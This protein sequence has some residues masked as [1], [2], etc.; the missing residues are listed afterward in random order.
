MPFREDF[1]ACF[2]DDN[3]AEDGLPAETIEC[4]IPPQKPVVSASFNEDFD[5]CFADDEEE[6]EE[7]EETGSTAD[8]GAS[9]IA[10]DVEKTAAETAEKR[11]SDDEFDCVR[12][13]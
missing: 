6:D 12:D 1:D 9:N 10:A 11:R 3:V 7:Q 2:A 8:D 13:Y 5:A 4:E